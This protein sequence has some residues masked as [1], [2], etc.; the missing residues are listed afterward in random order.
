MLRASFRP[1]GQ[2]EIHKLA[3]GPQLW[4][5]VAMPKDRKMTYS[6]RQSQASR[7]KKQ[8]SKKKA[9]PKED[10]SQA[11]ARVVRETTKD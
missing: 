8:Q 3:I 2:Y 6:D 5:T 11:A 4:E 9:V 10:F 1:L 7:A